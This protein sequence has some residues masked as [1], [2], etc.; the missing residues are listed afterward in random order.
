[1]TSFFK[2]LGA[3]LGKGQQK[4]DAPVFDEGQIRDD[5][6]R[7]HF[8]YA[9]DVVANW[10]GDVIDIDHAH[11]LDFGCGDGITDLGIKLRF[12]PLTV[13]GIDIRQNFNLLSAAAQTQLGLRK[14]PHNLNFIQ[15]A[16]GSRL[17]GKWQVDAIYSWSVFEH[18][19]RD[20]LREI[21][22][23]LYELLPPGGWFFLQI[24][25]LFY[26]PFGS[27]LGRFVELPWA[28]LLLDGNALWDAVRQQSGDFSAREKDLTFAAHGI[29]SYKRY[30]Y[31]EYLQLNRITADELAQQ[32]QAIGFDVVKQ[33][34]RQTSGPIPAEL[35]DRY[36]EAILRTNEIM[37][38]LRKP[39]N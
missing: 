18:V 31:N 2:T 27:H 9:A 22:T 10:L 5:W 26:S 3:V 15:V 21:I 11:L 37:L 7:V 24:E 30:I 8:R 17:A 6:F 34:R 20:L 16:P 38:L 19:E 28:H 25:P 39:A 32:F 23:D 12:K 33:E 36:D 29:D 1:M 4:Q 35:L 14:L 13:T